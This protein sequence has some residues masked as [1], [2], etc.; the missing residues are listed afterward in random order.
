MCFPFFKDLSGIILWNKFDK[1]LERWSIYNPFSVF[2]SY[3][4]ICC[5]EGADYTNNMWSRR[6]LR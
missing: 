5:A 6:Y 3:L 2:I 4:T 1:Y